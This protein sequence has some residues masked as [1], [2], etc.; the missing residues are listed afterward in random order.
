[1]NELQL[2]NEALEEDD[3]DKSVHYL[4]I[5]C[6]QNPN[7]NLYRTLAQLHKKRGDLEQSKSFFTKAISL[8]RK[9]I[10]LYLDLALL[11]PPIMK[12]NEIIF[13]VRGK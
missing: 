1:M 5:Y 12:S 3:L 9:N 6:T 10:A 13:H 11:C 4:E 7:S 8:D 2:A